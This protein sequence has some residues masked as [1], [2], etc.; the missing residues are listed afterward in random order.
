[1]HLIVLFHSCG[2]Y[3]LARLRV[4]HLACQSRA[5]TMTAVQVVG[6]TQEHPWGD[7]EDVSPF[8]LVTLLDAEQSDQSAQEYL[9]KARLTESLNHLQPDIAVLPGWGSVEARTAIAWCRQQGVPMV[10]MSESK[11]DDAP[12]QWWRE[13]LK[14]WLYVR[15]FD[16]ALVGGQHHADYLITLG[17]PAAKIFFGYDAV[18]NDH[19]IHKANQ[20]RADQ[21]AA[22]DRQPL[23]P[24]RPYFLAATRLI[25]RKNVSRLV[26]AYHQYRQQ[27][28]QDSW[29]LVIVGSGV[30][31]AALRQQVN[32]LGLE[33]AVHFP[34]FVPYQNIGDWYGLASAF[35]HPAWQEQW[36]LVVNEACA[37][38]LPILCS[39]T[40]G[41]RITLVE[42]GQNGLLFDPFDINDMLRALLAIH[43]LDKTQRLQW[44]QKSLELVSDYGPGKFAK[45]LMAC[46]D[47][48]QKNKTKTPVA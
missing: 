39:K 7:F 21:K 18:D 8:P 25:P 10:L 17:F 46:L 26:A 14:S 1:M 42:D 48:I 2:G 4:A 41:A 9:V 31:E 22:R 13:K 16:A 29:D 28:G 35:V 47:V 19:F 6:Q 38:S 36:G 27:V 43:R 37:S 11:T 24:K 15:H 32:Q 23:I 33:S 45:G 30:E 34:G 20:A 12:R 5:W 3:H 44:G 40:V